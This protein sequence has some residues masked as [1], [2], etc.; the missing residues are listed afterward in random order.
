M[1]AAR[2]W[3]AKGIIYGKSAIRIAASIDSASWSKRRRVDG[4]VSDSAGRAG[5]W[6]ELLI[7]NLSRIL[8]KLPFTSM[9]LMNIKGLR[10]KQSLI[11]SELWQKKNI[12][13]Y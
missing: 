1:S 12:Y 13:I 7:K 5:K 11:D 2:E 6:K 9:Y 10:E 4:I 3:R 8:F